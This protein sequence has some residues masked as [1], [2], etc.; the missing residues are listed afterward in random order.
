MITVFNYEK[1]NVLQKDWN[2]E[3]ICKKRDL[4][5]TMQYVYFF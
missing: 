1:F 2:F 5:H 4:T 3:Y